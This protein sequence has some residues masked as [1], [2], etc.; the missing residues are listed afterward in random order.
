MVLNVRDATNKH[1][2]VN[3][4]RHNFFL[5]Y[6]NHFYI[7]DFFSVA[8][9]AKVNKG[10]LLKISENSFLNVPFAIRINSKNIPIK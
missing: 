2:L 5:F 3:G 10:L 1:T 9:R 7:L 6:A 4:N 8:P